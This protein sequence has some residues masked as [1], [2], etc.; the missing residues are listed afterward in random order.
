MSLTAH[1]PVS[2][3]LGFAENDIKNPP[4]GDLGEKQSVK[5]FYWSLV[6]E[7]VGFNVPTS[8]FFHLFLEV[9]PVDTMFF[10]FCGEGFINAVF[11]TF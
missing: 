11:H 7:L 9:R 1:S 5:P 4:M 10:S 6:T 8:F 3:T 2:A